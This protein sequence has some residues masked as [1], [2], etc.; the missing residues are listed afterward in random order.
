[1]NWKDILKVVVTVVLPMVNPKLA[2]VS[3]LIIQGIT[4]AEDL[5]NASGQAKLQH[6]VDLVNTGAAS[7]NVVSGKQ[8]I[9]PV[10]VNATAASTISTIVDVTNLIHSAQ[11]TQTHQDFP[12]K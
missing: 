3:P 4:E 7:V 6:V 10:A 8:L 5:S 9:D 1:M 12:V 11:D 2:A